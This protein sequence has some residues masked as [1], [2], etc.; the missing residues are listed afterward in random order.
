MT[1]TVKTRGDTGSPILAEYA[2]PRHGVFEELVERPS[3]DYMPCPECNDV[4]PWTITVAPAFKPQYGAVHTGKV[5]DAPSPHAVDTR[6]IADG[7]PVTEWR[8]LRAKKR[9]E[10]RLAEIRSKI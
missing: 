10:R 7:M 6:A 3:P 9:R 5:D 8:E 4:S 1:F 2:C